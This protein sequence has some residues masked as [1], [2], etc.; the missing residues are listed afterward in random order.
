LLGSIE[1]RGYLAVMAYLDREIDA[2]AA[3]LR[4]A[5]GSATDRPVTFGWGPRFL[6]STGQYHKGGPANG[7]F[8]QITGANQ[9]DVPIPGRPYTF[10]RLQMA[11][12]LGDVAALE[13]RDRPVVRVHLR[14]REEGLRRLLSAADQIGAGST[15]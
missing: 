8:L 13:L 7:S 6:H 3:R 10:G 2:D 9:V 12:A 11:Q 14:D 1:D 4:D 5:I 15:A